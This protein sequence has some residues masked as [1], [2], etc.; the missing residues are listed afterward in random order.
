MNLQVKRWYDEL[1]KSCKFLQQIK[2]EL[3]V[4]EDQ[5]QQKHH[6]LLFKQNSLK[7]FY[8]N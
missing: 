8:N 1:E 6:S 7:K 5:R 2:C 3:L 4:D